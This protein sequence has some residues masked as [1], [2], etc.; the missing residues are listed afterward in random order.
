MT[1]DRW[2]MDRGWRHVGSRLPRIETSKPIASTATCPATLW[3]TT[4]THP[5]TTPL[6]FQS[7][8]YQQ[9]TSD[10]LTSHLRSH[11]IYPPA[12]TQTR[13]RAAYPRH[14]AGS[15]KLLP[16]SPTRPPR[17]ATETDGPRHL[18]VQ[19]WPSAVQGAEPRCGIAAR[20]QDSG[21]PITTLSISAC[22][23]QD[24]RHLLLRGCEPLA[25]DR[26]RTP[27]ILG[28]RDSVAQPFWGEPGQAR[29]SHNH[30]GVYP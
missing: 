15:P 28:S 22:K 8:W 13:L 29:A 27:V 23:V 21:T 1:D 16:W 12:L 25:L 4:A 24:Y 17:S 5:P 26:S 18:R 9:D 2:Q 6:R 30:G 7:E 3:D 19:D 14:R 11:S 20:N 10:P